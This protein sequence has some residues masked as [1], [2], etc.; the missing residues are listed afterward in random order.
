[1]ITRVLISCSSLWRGENIIPVCVFR[2]LDRETDKQAAPLTRAV[3][4]GGGRADC[5][6]GSGDYMLWSA[7]GPHWGTCRATV[8]PRIQ[9]KVTGGVKLQNPSLPSVSNPD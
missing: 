5:S 1:M 9:I 2:S 7:R 8:N 4:R 6:G 3:G